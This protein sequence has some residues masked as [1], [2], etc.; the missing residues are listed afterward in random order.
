[1]SASEPPSDPVES[2]NAPWNRMPKLP[3]SSWMGTT[4]TVE[5]LGFGISPVDKKLKLV[6]V[7]SPER[8]VPPPISDCSVTGA[9]IIVAAEHDVVHGDENNVRTKTPSVAKDLPSCRLIDA[10]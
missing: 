2:I 4:F 8:S 7:L 9:P 3:L 5:P 1:M 10:N 6:N